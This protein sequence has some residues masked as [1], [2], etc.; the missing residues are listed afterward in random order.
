MKEPGESRHRKG[1]GKAH[2]HQPPEVEQ[3]VINKLYS[4]TL[5][6]LRANIVP[7]EPKEG[8]KDKDKDSKDK[9]KEAEEETGHVPVV[10][11][12]EDMSEESIFKTDN[13]NWNALAITS[14]FSD[15]TLGA[16]KELL[17]CCNNDPAKV[18]AWLTAK[19]WAQR[20]MSRSKRMTMIVGS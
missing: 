12:S 2:R 3:K 8:V 9:E 19:G 15:V 5:P 11:H 6:N 20:R 14:Y 18:M 1:L 13:A 7:A 10:A 4:R 17:A 16:A